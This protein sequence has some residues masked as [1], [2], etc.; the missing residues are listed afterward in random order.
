MITRIEDEPI[1]RIFD[2]APEQVPAPVS[3]E[4]SDEQKNETDA[5][6]VVRNQFVIYGG[7]DKVA[8]EKFDEEIRSKETIEERF[9]VILRFIGSATN[10]W[11]RI[12][13]KIYC[14]MYT[15]LS[16]PRYTWISINRLRDV[17]GMDKTKIRTLLSVKGYQ[18]KRLMR[19]DRRGSLD[20]DLH[21]FKLDPKRWVCYRN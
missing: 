10:S 14:G 13:R 7:E 8:V 19:V 6:L 12:C 15:D 21:V 2:P 5:Y 16:F 9:E 11:M 18:L 4:D 20:A 1:P 17:L 3:D